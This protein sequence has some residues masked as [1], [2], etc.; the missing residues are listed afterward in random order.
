MC[1]NKNCKFEKWVMKIWEKV[2]LF[3]K[4]IEFEKWILGMLS[5]N[6]FVVTYTSGGEVMSQDVLSLVIKT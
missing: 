2:K 4:K 6:V 1:L 5:I 3:T